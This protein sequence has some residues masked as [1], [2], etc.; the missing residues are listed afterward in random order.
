MASPPLVFD[1]D[2]DIDL[3]RRDGDLPLAVRI[4]RA[5]SGDIRRGRLR[6][7]TELPS[8]RAL[9]AALGVH[10]NTALAAYAEL[11]AEGWIETRPRRGTF[12]S[13]AM[14]ERPA[15]RFAPAVSAPPE[16]PGFPL[17][18]PPPATLGLPPP[19]T[20]G[21]DAL[22]LLGGRPDLRLAPTVALARAYRRALRGTRGRTLLDYGDPAGNPRLRAALVELLA[23]TRGIVPRVE[24]LMV[25]RGSQMALVL[26]ARTILAPGDVVAVEALGYRPAWAALDLAGARLAPIPVDDDGLD[27]AALERLAAREPRL[28][29]VYVTPHHQYPTTATL[30]APRRVALLSVARTRRL[31]VIEDDYDHEFHYDGRPILPLAAADEGG[32]VVSIGTLSKV[33]APGVRLGWLVG[34]AALVERAAALRRVV[35]RQG[36]LA[37]EEA[38]AALVE[39]GEL[40]RHVRRTRRVYEGRRAAF[41]A[42]LER[43]LGGALTYRAPAGGMA[44]WA[45]AA[46]RVDVDAWADRTAARGVLLQTARQFR[47][48]GAPA[49]AMRLGFASLD[50]RELTEAVR[51]LAATFRR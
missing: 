13:A 11:E 19:S 46:E 22:P 24:R 15:R 49:P 50:E 32:N 1:L 27:V 38:L 7:G 39:D 51:R 3:R 8:S 37:V 28:R 5:I 6:P 42:L 29:A 4:A 17:A 41:L 2:L 34:P 35:D 26:A 43:H 40:E 31:A 45:R 25:T 30:T 10:R 9:A 23:A 12:V 44:L 14:P 16:A 21:P 47:F 36:D 48:D 18:P 20:I 33:L